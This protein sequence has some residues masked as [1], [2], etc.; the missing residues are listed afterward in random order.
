VHRKIKQTEN[1]FLVITADSVAAKKVPTDESA[2]TDIL[3]NEIEVDVN[4]G[5]KSHR[6]HLL[7]R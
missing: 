3:K 5:H 7:Y 6:V 4:V 2:L 1:H